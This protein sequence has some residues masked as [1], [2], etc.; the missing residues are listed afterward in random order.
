MPE[1]PNRYAKGKNKKNYEKSNQ[2]QNVG[3]N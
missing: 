2:F 3:I 1:K